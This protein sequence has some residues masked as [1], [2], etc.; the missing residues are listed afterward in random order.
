[1]RSYKDCLIEYLEEQGFSELNLAWYDYVQSSL[2]AN[3]SNFQ[4]MESLPAVDQISEYNFYADIIP[5]DLLVNKFQL[6]SVEKISEVYKSLISSFI[7]VEYK[8]IQFNLEEEKLDWEIC[9]GLLRYP[10]KRTTIGFTETLKKC[11]KKSNV[12]EETVEAYIQNVKRNAPID[13]FEVI[14]RFFDVRNY[15]LNLPRYTIAPSKEPKRNIEINF[16]SQIHFLSKNQKW[17]DSINH[18]SS[19][20]FQ[21]NSEELEELNSIAKRSGVKVYG[22]LEGVSKIGVHTGEWLEE[23]VIRSLFSEKRLQLVEDIPL[24]Q[25]GKYE[26][27]L[28]KRYASFYTLDSFDLIMEINNVFSNEQLEILKGLE[29]TVFPF[30]ISRQHEHFKWINLM[31][32]GNLRI[33]IKSKKPQPTII[34]AELKIY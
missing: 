11:L 13:L 7:E 14:E 15:H 21:G 10:Q 9:Q 32:N 8:N 3:E 20:F 22:N 34:G 4:L 18:V 12:N 17:T 29:F 6:F 2:Q 16:N 1:M 28:N 19:N 33:Q 31:K 24:E 25:R 27:K 26:E 5:D 30:H 23:N